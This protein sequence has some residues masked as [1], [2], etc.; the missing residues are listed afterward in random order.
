MK[1]N[2]HARL[3]LQHNVTLEARELIVAAFHPLK[4]L[5]NPHHRV[6]HLGQ[7]ELLSDADP[8]PAVERDVRPRARRPVV[9][10][11]GHE[12]EVVWEAGAGGWVDVWSA[13]HH[14]C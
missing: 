7:C 6:S 12:G 10:A 4:R 5:Q 11:L 8:W 1:S 3:W 9:P 13:L 14:E 2:L